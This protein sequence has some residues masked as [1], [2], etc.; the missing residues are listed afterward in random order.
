[1]YCW[2]KWNGWKRDHSRILQTWNFHSSFNIYIHCGNVK[3]SKTKISSTKKTREIF[4]SPYVSYLN[5]TSFHS[6]PMSELLSLEKTG[7]IFRFPNVS[8]L[9]QT[10]FHSFPM[11]EM[12]SLETRNC[13][14]TEISF[15]DDFPHWKLWRKFGVSSLF[16]RSTSVETVRFLQDSYLETISKFCH[17]LLCSG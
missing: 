9:H 16:P 12:P 3:L 11:S 8:Y 7:E 10:S 15:S 14:E 6:F 1:M 17:F 5:P 2:M 4:R 13:G